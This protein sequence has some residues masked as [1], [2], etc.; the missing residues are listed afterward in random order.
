MLR[1]L[2][3]LCVLAAPLSASANIFD[4]YGMG[5][6]G[7]G[8]GGAQAAQ[9]NDYTATFYNPAALARS[10]RI[11]FGGGFTFTSPEL[12]V[13]RGLAESDFEAVLPQSFSGF[14][15]GWL[16]PLGGVFENKLATGIVFYVPSINLVR[17]ESLDPQ[18]PQFY[19]YQNLPDQLVILASLAYEPVEWLSFGVGVQVLADVFGEARFQVDLVNGTFEQYDVR[20]ELIPNAAA[21]AGLHIR[22][23]GGLDIGGT[24]RQEHGLQFG[25]PAGIAAG[26][27]IAL[28]LDVGGSVLYTPHQIN[29]GVSWK[30]DAID[31]TVSAEVDYAMWSLAPDPSPSLGIDFGGGLLDAFGL[32]KALDIGTERPPIELNFRDTVTP[33]LGL[34]WTPLEWLAVWSGYYVRPTAAPRAS[35]PFNY[36]DNDVHAVSLGAAFTFDDPFVSGRPI[37]IQIASQLGILPRRT[38]VKENRGDPVGDLEHGGFTMS[39]NVTVNHSF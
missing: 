15:L 31:L 23:V 7:I 5:A 28:G 33:R 27:V 12:T 30:F 32:D 38:V 8:M 17:A 18:T 20:V 35:G 36:L 19:M 2:L 37:S 24:Y 39:V 14:H 9:A 22:P 1:A 26:D 29:V 10:K 11:T 6:R 4:V 16:F 34:E 3:A 21:T 25:L 13:T